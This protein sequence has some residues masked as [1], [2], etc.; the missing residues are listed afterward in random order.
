MMDDLG[1]Q[2]NEFREQFE[3][4]NDGSDGAVPSDEVLEVAAY[5]E[6]QDDTTQEDEVNDEVE[7]LVQ[8][9]RVQAQAPS[10]SGKK[11]AGYA[12]NARNAMATSDA[13]RFWSSVDQTGLGIGSLVRHEGTNLLTGKTINTYAIVTEA[14][15][16]TLGLDDFASHVYES[17]ARPPLKS[18]EPAPSR[19]RPVV[20]YGAKVL[21]SSEQ[22]QRPVL[23]GPVYELAAGEMAAVHGEGADEGSEETEWPTGDRM[24]LGFYEDSAGEFGAFAEERSRVLGP[25][26]GHVVLSGL[27]GAGKTSL[28][29]TSVISLYAQAR[30]IDGLQEGG[31]EDEVD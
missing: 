10:T 25:K 24:L 29:L 30:R 27:P 12:S 15:G 16:S 3:S 8:A 1:A 4:A 11:P 13:F 18:I 6:E 31:D 9:A 5:P 23:T 17:D 19:R 2:L 7:A 28:F 20:D 26:Q 22:S 21:A 14:D